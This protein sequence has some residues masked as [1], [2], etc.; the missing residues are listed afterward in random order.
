MYPS[1]QDVLEGNTCTGVLDVRHA[2]DA[3]TSTS[4]HSS[5]VVD[6]LLACPMAESSVCVHHLPNV[7]STSFYFLGDSI[8]VALLPAPAEVPDVC[9]MHCGICYTS[10]VE[11][12]SM[13][14]FED[15]QQISTQ[16]SAISSNVDHR[17][18]GSYTG[19]VVSRYIPK[20]DFGSQTELTSETAETES[21]WVSGEVPEVSSSE[22]HGP[23]EGKPKRAI[24]VQ[25]DLVPHVTK[26]EQGC[27]AKIVGHI[28][29]E[30]YASYVQ[31]QESLL[32]TY[33]SSDIHAPKDIIRQKETYQKEDAE[34]QTDMQNL[35]MTQIETH[36]V[37]DRKYVL[38]D[39]N[40]Q[41]L[42]SSVKAKPEQ[43]TEHIERSIYG[44]TDAV[45]FTETYA[46]KDRK[47]A[48]EKEKAKE[49]G[50]LQVLEK[51]EKQR[52]H[53][54]LIDANNWRIQ[55]TEPQTKVPKT[56]VSVDRTIRMTD[57]SVSYV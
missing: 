20:L 12:G 32:T 46:E 6:E 9:D 26:L 27:E 11:S 44:T 51:T 13:Y 45:V 40:R 18:F 5:L 50:I 39:E 28:F 31:T 3:F 19:T 38:V 22:S 33:P 8:D 43:P 15:V 2:V 10:V 35:D 57:V 52:K 14:V 21:S 49:Q 37:P 24:E 23:A 4:F 17:S 16:E 36:G 34:T 7:D 41:H 54:N 55:T 56:S 47:E 30:G 29:T 48:A 53:S 1:I 25:C 42:T